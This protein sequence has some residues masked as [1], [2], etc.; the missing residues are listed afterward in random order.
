MTQETAPRTPR[1]LKLE[2]VARSVTH[3]ML[4]GRII[5]GF[6]SIILGLARVNP[7]G[8]FPALAVSFGNNLLFGTLLLAG[9]S[10]LLISAPWRLSAAG[11]IIAA[12]AAAIAGAWGIA[13]AQAS[14][15]SALIATLAVVVLLAEAGAYD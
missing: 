9:G 12:V 1:L 5:I 2:H 14:P 3:R 15:A 7:L 10:S 4:Q 6:L 13:V 8:V 11:K